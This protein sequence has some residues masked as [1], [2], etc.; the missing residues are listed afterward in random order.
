MELSLVHTTRIS[1]LSTICRQNP[2]MGFRCSIGSDQS[3]CFGSSKTWPEKHADTLPTPTRYLAGYY[4]YLNEPQQLQPIRVQAIGR[5]KNHRQYFRLRE[6]RH[7]MSLCRADD[8]WWSHVPVQFF[9][10][11]N[12]FYLSLVLVLMFIFVR[13]LF[14]HQKKSLVMCYPYHQSVIWTC[15]FVLQD[16]WSQDGM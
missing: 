9:T 1:A 4:K 12:F 3:L 7:A 13:F 15:H 2:Q 10:K 11:Y 6:M 8:Q 16:F 5:W 14:I